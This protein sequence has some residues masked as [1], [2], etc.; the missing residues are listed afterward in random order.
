M[1]TLLLLK[2][3]YF[4]GIQRPVLVPRGMVESAVQAALVP[5]H[6][7]RAPTPRIGNFVWHERD[8]GVLPP[9]NP[10]RDPDYSDAWNEW[11]SFDYDG[12]ELTFEAPDALAWLV[13]S[14]DRQPWELKPQPRAPKRRAP[15]APFPGK[16]VPP[17]WALPGSQPVP[18]LEPISVPTF[19]LS[20]AGWLLL[21]LLLSRRRS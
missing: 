18:P 2:G 20:G 9:V 19:D 13:T 21:L 15:K 3:P 1:K 5:Q 7:G 14:S 16:T 10:K 8:S 12:A 4:A 11:V 6:A 17:T